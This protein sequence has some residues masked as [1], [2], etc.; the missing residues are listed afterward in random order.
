[1]AE[2]RRQKSEQ[3]LAVRYL[4]NEK[5]KEVSALLKQNTQQRKN[6]AL[7]SIM[8]RFSEFH[9]H[10]RKVCESKLRLKRFMH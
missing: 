1:M 2:Q 4:R 8:A 9:D 7:T 5:R 3:L 6:Q 10:Y